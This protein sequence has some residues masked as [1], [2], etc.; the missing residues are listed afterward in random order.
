MSLRTGV[1]TVALSGGVFLNQELVVRC[2]RM[3]EREGLR[4]LRHH[5]VPTNDG[6]LSFGQA[7][8]AAATVG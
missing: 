1:R 6:G 2:H 5:R 8:V 4:V 3:L 7:L